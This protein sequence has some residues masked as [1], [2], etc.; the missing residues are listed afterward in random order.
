LVKHP[1]T[2]NL[3]RRLPSFCAGGGGGVQAVC[4]A[5][6]GHM[7]RTGKLCKQYAEQEK[8]CMKGVNLVFEPEKMY[9]VLGAPRSGKSTLLKMIAG[10]LQEDPEHQVGGSISAKSF[11]TKTKDVVWSNF[12]GTNSPVLMSPLLSIPFLKPFHLIRRLR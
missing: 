9:L 7:F 3:F 5:H 11:D 4:C 6:A 2:W 8:V 1:S 10:I 12:V